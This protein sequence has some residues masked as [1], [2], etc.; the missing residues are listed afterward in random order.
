M[1]YILRAN[2][3]YDFYLHELAM[4]EHGIKI[5]LPNLPNLYDLDPAIK[6]PG[7]F[8]TRVRIVFVTDNVGIDFLINTIKKNTWLLSAIPD[9]KFDIKIE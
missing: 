9:S 5:D 4:V 8:K 6:N 3:W 1:N 2:H 7:L